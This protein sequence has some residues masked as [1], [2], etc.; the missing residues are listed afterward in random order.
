MKRK[1]SV[2]GMT[3]SACENHVHNSVCKLP[4]V[5]HVEVNL[6]TNSMNVEFDETKVDD[7]MIIKAVKDGGYQASS[8]DDALVDN[9][10]LSNLKRKLIYCFI[11]LGLLMY[12]SMS[13]MLSYPIPDII[14]DNVY[15]N[16]ILQIIFLI[17]ILILKKDYFVNGFK[18][19]IH[20]DPTMDS[21]IA[22]GA[23]AA[24]VYSI[25]SVVLAL[26]GSL[27]EMH[28]VHNV[29]FES[30]GMIVTLISFGKYLE[31]K[32]KTKTT[33]AIGK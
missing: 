14:R 27:M 12:V 19:L 2:K 11:A 23:G 25:Y 6:L 33:D 18:N 5:E 22:L 1:Y 30:A 31:A 16:I 9:D 7:S 29:Y 8:Y 32:S 3:C 13:S 26:S 15:F 28:L 21:L 10:D 4:G 17:P 24:I 20:F